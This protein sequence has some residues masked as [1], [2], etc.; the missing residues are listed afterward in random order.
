[1]LKNTNN[2]SNFVLRNNFDFS[3]IY[4][5]S[6]LPLFKVVPCMGTANLP[7][8]AVL[9][10]K[11]WRK[12]ILFIKSMSVFDR[13]SSHN[14]MIPELGQRGYPYFMKY[15][16][17]NSYLFLTWFEP[18]MLCSWNVHLEVSQCS[19]IQWSMYSNR[20]LFFFVLGIIQYLWCTS[21]V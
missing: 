19:N 20:F 18:S 15:F 4:C 5:P 7:M 3:G 16:F 1:M 10:M 8:G 17:S 9:A 12:E 11:V 21:S 6:P 14:L 13:A 2:L